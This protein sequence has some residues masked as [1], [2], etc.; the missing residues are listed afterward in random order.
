[1]NY[2]AITDIIVNP[3]QLSTQLQDFQLSNSVK[4]SPKQTSIS[5]A[6]ILAK[7]KQNNVQEVKKE[8]SA[9][10]TKVENRGKTDAAEKPVES[11]SVDEKNDDTKISDYNSDNHNVKKSQNEEQKENSDAGKNAKSEKSEDSKVSVKKDIKDEKKLTKK[12]FSRLNELSKNDFDESKITENAERLVVTNQTS[13][14]L[15]LKTELK[16]EKDSEQKSDELLIKTDASLEL[17]LVQPSQIDNKSDSLVLH[18]SSR[19]SNSKCFVIFSDFLSPIPLI[20]DRKNVTGFNSSSLTE[21][22]TTPPYFFASAILEV[23]ECI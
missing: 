15:K 23:I 17:S 22:L 19:Q 3:S 8:E 18:K 16:S 4:D 14:A 12:D 13:D 6:D 9:S 21:G 10:E 2:Q 1:M 7:E 11:Q 5:F 20:P